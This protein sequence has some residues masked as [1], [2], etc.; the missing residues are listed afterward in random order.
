M[1]S[2]GL[3]ANCGRAKLGPQ[4]G[5]YVAFKPLFSNRVWQHTQILIIGA[6]LAPG[7]RTITSVLRIMGL[8]SETH[9]QNYHRVLN[10]AIWS[11]LKASRI[12]L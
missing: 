2:S 11:S 4:S 10:R 8:S 1:F 5:K 7:K 12:L 3:H 6:I 9:F